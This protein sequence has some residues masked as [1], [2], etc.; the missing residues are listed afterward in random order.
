MPDKPS[1]PILRVATVAALV[2]SLVFTVRSGWHIGLHT[3]Y[4]I[5]GKP[6]VAVV[7]DISRYYATV[8]KPR[9]TS[10]ASRFRGQYGF[11]LMM[12]SGKFAHITGRFDTSGFIGFP[13]VEM[14]PGDRLSVKYLSFYPSWSR[15]VA[16]L[17][18]VKLFIAA[19]IF[20]VSSFFSAVFLLLSKK[21]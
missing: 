17:G 2:I 8:R 19:G 18:L 20:I 7:G 3:G 16:D 4:A 5:W 14:L 9:P 21:I 1:S 10:Y 15:P 11:D 13:K 12:D 6:A